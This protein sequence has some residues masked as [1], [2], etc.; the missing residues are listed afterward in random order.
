[1][2]DD[3]RGSEGEERR[4]VHIVVKMGVESS[5]TTTFASVDD[6]RA[7]A[8]EANDDGCGGEHA[9]TSSSSSSSSSRWSVPRL[10]TSTLAT[11]A[12]ALGAL[13]LSSAATYAARRGVGVGTSAHHRHR[14]MASLG[15]RTERHV[16]E[17]K[18]DDVNAASDHGYVSVDQQRAFEAR[19][20]AWDQTYSCDDFQ[21]TEEEFEAMNVDEG[22]KN[23]W[24]N[25]TF[26]FQYWRTP[27]SRHYQL[28]DAYNLR[29]A[30]CAA[31]QFDVNVVT[32]MDSQ[33]SCAWAKKHYD[34]GREK[35]PRA[36]P[37]RDNLGQGVFFCAGRPIDHFVLQLSPV[38]GV[39]S[40][41]EINRMNNLG[42]LLNFAE[43]SG[44]ISY[45]YAW[46]VDPEDFEI[47]MIHKRL[48]DPEMDAAF[49]T[50]LRLECHRDGDV[51]RDDNCQ[52]G[53]AISPRRVFNGRIVG[54]RRKTINN[55][56]WSVRYFL[57][58]W[59]PLKGRN[60]E[61]TLDENGVVSW[62]IANNLVKGC[63]CPSDEELYTQ[64]AHV[65]HGGF[66]MSFAFENIASSTAPTPRV[67][68]EEYGTCAWVEFGH[69]LGRLLE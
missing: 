18:G 62:K 12:M 1:V 8:R 19:A 45:T 37:S 30:L 3:A 38:C 56:N 51:P 57:R 67:V 55:Y 23:F 6:R 5:T 59:V 11:A 46:Y 27:R 61:W 53:T 17:G 65:V 36:N 39:R 42:D 9:R 40:I 10:S 54:G 13:A 69:R 60:H 35:F 20:W 63:V 66:A 28:Y 29:K 14:P 24:R 22:H 16:F 26:S 7:S 31:G 44:Q 32:M 2:V 4:S 47:K 41:I 68:G 52:E 25:T 48:F 34:L 50:Q 15:Q 43:R 49:P 58:K 64:M 21:V 33:D